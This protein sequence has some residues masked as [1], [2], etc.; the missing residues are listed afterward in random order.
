MFTKNMIVEKRA[1][2]SASAP[3]IVGIIAPENRDPGGLVRKGKK[4]IE[5]ETYVEIHH[6]IEGGGNTVFEEE[7]LTGD[8]VGVSD[9][10]RHRN[11]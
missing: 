9:G 10:L 7:A 11:Q 4:E 5:G 2:I 1:A 8:L 6:E 3:K